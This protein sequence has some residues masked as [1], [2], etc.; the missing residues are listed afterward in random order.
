MDYMLANYSSPQ[1]MTTT[2]DLT[3]SDEEEEKRQKKLQVPEL[4]P[5][6]LPSA[7]I[8]RYLKLTCIYMEFIISQPSVSSM[9]NTNISYYK[10]I[11]G[12]QCYAS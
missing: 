7:S 10:N 6:A 11:I 3:K 4:E 5:D 1:A 12:N 8:Q 2:L 9:V